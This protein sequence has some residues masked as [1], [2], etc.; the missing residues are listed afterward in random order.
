MWV[1]CVAPPLIRILG[2]PGASWGDPD[3]YFGTYFTPAAVLKVPDVHTLLGIFTLC[4]ITCVHTMIRGLCRPGKGCVAVAAAAVLGEDQM[5]YDHTR[6]N[7]G[8]TP[9]SGLRPFV[10]CSSQQ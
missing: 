8:G 7:S 1:V 10:L 2:R 9:S 5:R 6:L 4:T 3:T